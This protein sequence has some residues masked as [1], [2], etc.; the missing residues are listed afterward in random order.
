MFV[1]QLPAS[2]PTGPFNQKQDEHCPFFASPSWRPHPSVSWIWPPGQGLMT[3]LFQGIN[4]FSERRIKPKWN[5]E[6]I[7]LHGNTGTSLTSSVQISSNDFRC[8]GQFLRRFL[9]HLQDHP[10]SSKSTSKQ[11]GDTSR[12]GWGQTCLVCTECLTRANAPM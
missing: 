11:C 9:C 3:G 12:H 4:S 1:L 2:T 5:V 8:P 10:C 6:L 7:D